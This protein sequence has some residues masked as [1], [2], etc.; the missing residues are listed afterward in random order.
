MPE[1]IATSVW[2]TAAPM[3]THSSFVTDPR[4]SIVPGD[5]DEPVGGMLPLPQLKEQVC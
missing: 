3:R 4:Q 2:V 1:G 5:I